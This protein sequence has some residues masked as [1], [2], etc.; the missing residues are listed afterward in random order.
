[1]S[2]CRTVMATLALTGLVAI[3]SATIAAQ[4]PTV[5]RG[6][7]SAQPFSGTSSAPVVLRGTPS[8]PAPAGPE[9]IAAAPCPAGYVFDANSGCIGAELAS[10]PYDDDWL[11]GYPLIEPRQ[12]FRQRFSASRHPQFRRGIAKPG[13]LSHAAHPAF[14]RH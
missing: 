12:R 7:T 8:P 10:A 2:V 14:R 13:P 9:P 6:P 5:L 1:M 4:T 11:L 3:D